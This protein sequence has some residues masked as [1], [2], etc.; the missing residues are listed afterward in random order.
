VV[1]EEVVAPDACGQNVGLLPVGG[2]LA[3]RCARVADQLRRSPPAG[4]S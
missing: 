1:K 3:R 4:V 2:L